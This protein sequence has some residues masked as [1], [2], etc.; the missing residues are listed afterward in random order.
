MLQT[1]GTNSTQNHL[2]YY[3]HW[4]LFSFNN[5]GDDEGK[6]D[7]DNDV[8]HDNNNDDNNDNNNYLDLHAYCVKCC[9]SE[10][11]VT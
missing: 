10:D 11:F 7:E 6:H 9:V 2:N 8:D 3:W 5:D 4:L 1:F